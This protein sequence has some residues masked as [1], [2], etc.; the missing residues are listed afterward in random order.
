MK[1]A[2]ALLSLALALAGCAS[3]DKDECRNANW[4]AI[5]LEDGAQGRGIQRVGDHRRACAEHNVQPDVDRYTAG[6]NEGLKTF[7]T[8]DRGYR[9]GINGNSYSGACP[10]PMQQDFLAGYGRGKEIHSLDKRLDEVNAEI[11]KT[12]SGL[13]EPGTSPRLRAVLAEKLDG[14]SREAADLERQ[15]ARAR[16]RK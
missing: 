11:K 16:S 8:Y 2:P 4:Y 9:H 12:K 1:L 10:E 15:L 5:G 6:R 7:C 14:L 13:S 3:L